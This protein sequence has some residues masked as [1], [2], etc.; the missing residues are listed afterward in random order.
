MEIKS[1]EPKFP[2]SKKLVSTRDAFGLT[3]EELGHENKRIVVLTADLATSTR[4]HLFANSYPERFFNI[5]ISEQDMI[6]ISSGLA[7]CGKIPIVVTYACFLIGR[8]LDQI[9]NMVA[10]DQLNVKLIGTHAGLATGKDGA[11]HQ[12]LE[13]ISI[14]R[15]IPHITILSPADAI[16][17]AAMLEYLI[18]VEGPIYLRLS[19]EK[20]PIIHLRNYNFNPEKIEL[21]GTIEK[22]EVVLFAT[23]SMV[24]RALRA[25]ELLEEKEIAVCVANVHT[26]KPIDKETIVKIAQNI[27]LAFSLEDHNIIGGLGSSI[28]D[29][30]STN[31]VMI[32]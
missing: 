8:G 28:A 27:P 12:A 5:G 23:G 29:I 32:L 30:Y 2:E 1:Q 10:Y 4:V 11:T 7:S 6:S 15:S 16:E 19:R 21:F 20:R 31:D 26:I 25:A 22:K 24:A 9:R 14:L 3:L 18:S 13:D 17:T